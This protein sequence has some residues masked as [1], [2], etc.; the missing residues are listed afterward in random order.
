[1]PRNKKRKTDRGVGLSTEILMRASEEIFATNESIRSVAMKYNICHV[2]LTRYCRKRKE[3]MQQGSMEV[4]GVGYHSATQVF[5]AAQEQL[6][7][8]YFLTSASFYYGLSPQETRKLAYQL[9]V[10]HDC[11]MPQSWE[12][13]KSA[14]PDWMSGFMKRHPELSIRSPQATSLSRAISFN[15]SNVTLFFDN[16]EAVLS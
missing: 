4:P 1:M 15:R 10:K 6:L 11:K 8:K 9:A 14:G 12:N 2:T 3:L 16:Y 13:N 7:S 5:T